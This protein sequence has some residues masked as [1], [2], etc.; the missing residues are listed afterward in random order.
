MLKHRT[1][2]VGAVIALSVAL[3]GAPM[4]SAATH[5]PP[6]ATHTAFSF[7]PPTINQGGVVNGVDYQANDIHPG[8]VVA[9]F[10]QWFLPADTVIVNQGSN[11]WTIGAGSSWW[12]DS[13]GQ[14]NATLPTDLQLGQATVTVLTSAGQ[15]SNAAPITIS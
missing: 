14:I 1:W 9:I 6:A 5:T 10:G 2:P 12:Y 4:A 7:G 11:Q 13:G 8:T 3:S 15:Y